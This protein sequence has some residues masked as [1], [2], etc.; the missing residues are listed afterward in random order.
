M[1]W[2]IINLE[3]L[4]CMGVHVCVNIAIYVSNNVCVCGFPQNT[5]GNTLKTEMKTVII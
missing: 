1:I 5:L 4:F 2:N 3:L